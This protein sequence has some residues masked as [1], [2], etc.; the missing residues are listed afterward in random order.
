MFM[1]SKVWHITWLE[2]E[3]INE[4]YI[5]ITPRGKLFP[6]TKTEDNIHLEEILFE[7]ILR[8]SYM[9]FISE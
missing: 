3:T 8:N 4:L 9:S 6:L 2:Q 1:K 5:D 7:I